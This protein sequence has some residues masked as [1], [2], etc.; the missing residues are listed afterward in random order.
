MLGLLSG[1]GSLYQ[2]ATPASPSRCAKRPG[3]TLLPASLVEAMALGPNVPGSL[4][5]VP[6]L[7][8]SAAVH[9]DANAGHSE[10]TFAPSRRPVA[11]DAQ[12][13]I[14]QLTLSRP[15]MAAPM[16]SGSLAA[17]SSSHKPPMIN[18]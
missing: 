15:A 1:E 16:P 14:W 3:S 13:R 17:R 2:K 4:C 18:S 7:G 5:R 12:I 9:C 10:Q 6:R 11:K 8:L